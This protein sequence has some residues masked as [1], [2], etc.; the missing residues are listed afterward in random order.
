[1][2]AW[3]EIVAQAIGDHEDASGSLLAGGPLIC[4]D[5][6]AALPAKTLAEAADVHAAHRAQAV[7]DA[8]AKAGLDVGGESS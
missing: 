4:C 2:T 1:M 8:L 3:R 6:G 5:C 7:L